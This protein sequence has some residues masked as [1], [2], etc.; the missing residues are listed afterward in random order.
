MGKKVLVVSRQQGK[1][2]GS[3]DFVGIACPA[4]RTHLLYGNASNY[5]VHVGLADLI[6]CTSISIAIAGLQEEHFVTMKSSIAYLGGK[7]TP[8]PP[9]TH[10]TTGPRPR[11]FHSESAIQNDPPKQKSGTGRRIIIRGV[12]EMGRISRRLATYVH[13][14]PDARPT[15]LPPFRSIYSAF[16]YAS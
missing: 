13:T 6:R 8:R 14:F 1:K 4:E 16:M 12:T 2:Y 15:F 3:R 9:G 10:A 7:R 5:T 11:R